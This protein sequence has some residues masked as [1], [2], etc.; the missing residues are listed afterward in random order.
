MVEAVRGMS[1]QVQAALLGV[2]GLVVGTSL[3]SYPRQL[4]IATCISGEIHPFTGPL[5]GRSLPNSSPPPL[6]DT[7]AD[8]EGEADNPYE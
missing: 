4:S 5:R 1:P 7:G 2:G 3:G 6:S 8:K